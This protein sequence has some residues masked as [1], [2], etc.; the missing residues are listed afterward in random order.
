MRLR[1]AHANGSGSLHARGHERLR[2]HAELRNGTR[3]HDRGYDAD[4]THSSV[5]PRIR[6]LIQASRPHLRS[7]ADVL[8]QAAHVA[9][10]DRELLYTTF[11]MD[12]ALSLIHI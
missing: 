5:L 10:A 6:R 4:D 12:K 11:Q 2:A 8:R 3:G 1:A 7:E 9:T